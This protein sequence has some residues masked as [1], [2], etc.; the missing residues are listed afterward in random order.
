MFEHV[1]VLI[2]GAGDLATGVAA[3]LHRA[4]FP[5][6]MTEVQ[7]P[8]VIRRTVAL[9]EAVFEGQVQVEDLVA[10]RAEAPDVVKGLIVEG[11]IPVLVDPELRHLRALG[12]QVLVDA[13]LAKR[14]LGLSLSLAPLV[15]GVG[16]GFTA[17]KDV[18]A[19]IDS[20]R[21]HFL[22]RVY[23][24]GS[25][26]PDTGTPGPIAG[27]STERVVRAPATGIFRGERAIGDSVQA[28][29]RLGRVDAEPVLA[30]ISGVLRGLLHDGLRVRTGMKI[31]DVD[32][33]DVPDHC[34]TISDKAL[35]IGGG[36]LE[37]VLSWLHHCTPR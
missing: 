25:A 15:V 17:G 36:V 2:R 7:H 18:H 9:A 19:V 1:L 13:T 29:Q 22:G 24:R 35:A 14:N 32:P 5:L 37:A 28:G 21:G 16:P 33:R 3:R 34:W 10:R 30:P 27:F 31:G 26:L 11:T 23:W 4:G 12:P 6:A 20:Q 8:T